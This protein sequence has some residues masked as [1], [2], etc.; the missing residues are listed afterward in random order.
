LL[1]QEIAT[2]Y[3]E[4]VRFV[5]EDLGASKLA[6]SFGVDKYPAVFVDDA[7]VARPE[8]FYEW[9]G[10]ATG[11][12]IP[13]KELANRRKFQ[14][15]LQQMIDIRLAGGAIASLPP[16]AKTAETKK[17]LP[18]VDL[19]GLDGKT[20]RF[21]ALRGKA[22]LIEFW[23]PWCP[24]CMTTLGWLRKLDPKMVEVIAIAIE[25]PREDIDRA[26]QKQLVPGRVVIGSNEVR[27][28]F[29]GPPA[30]PTLL[31][32]DGTGNIARIFYGA[33][34]TLHADIEKEL[35]RLNAR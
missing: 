5:V 21:S 29:G 10:P 26:V 31:I 28:A 9:G 3:G 32:A 6:D 2:R 4:K 23:A 11:K 17:L 24:H 12:Y 35:T 8:D 20:F 30:I 19:L 14:A 1:A 7:L 13:W 22:V 18:D 33:S 34:P 27:K 15:D 25:S 16:S